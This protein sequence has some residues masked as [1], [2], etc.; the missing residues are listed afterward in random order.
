VATKN[1]YGKAP[2]VISRKIPC[3]RERRQQVYGGAGHSRLWYEYLTVCRGLLPRASISDLKITLNPV[4]RMQEPPRA[5]FMTE[6]VGFAR[7]LEEEVICE[8]ETRIG[9]HFIRS[10]PATSTPS[11]S[12]AGRTM[13][14][15]R[16]QLFADS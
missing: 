13:E 5:I 16:T 8:A 15:Y 4:V 10:V 3:V 12:L 14:K 11:E 6:I 9:C 7:Y 2:D 1:L